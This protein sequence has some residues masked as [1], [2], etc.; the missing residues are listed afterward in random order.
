MIN[1][2]GETIVEVLIA[3][4]VLGAA[5][6]SALAISNKSVKQTQ[7]NHERYQAQLYANEQAEL[8]RQD[9]ALFITNGNNR[10]NYD[11]GKGA[12]SPVGAGLCY[13]AS[14]PPIC[15]DRDDPQNYDTVISDLSGGAL[16]GVTAKTYRIVVS[17]DSLINGTQDKVEVIYGL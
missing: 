14:K 13:S 12:G 15:T 7:A 9:Y 5:L 8:L 10:T 4:V 11:P 17:W 16:T 1:N 2:K 6:G 3:I